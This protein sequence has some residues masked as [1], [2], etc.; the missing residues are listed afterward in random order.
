MMNRNIQSRKR[1]FAAFFIGTLI[2]ILVFAFTYSLSYVEFNRISNLQV[3]LAYKI[4]E[5]KLDYDL[6]E[7]DICS[8]SSYLEISESLGFQGRII[9]IL[10]RKL[11]KDNEGVLSR[12]KFYTLIELEHF[13]FVNNL[14]ENCGKE[15]ITLLFF[16]SNKG[17]QLDE[18]EDVGAMLGVVYDRNR[19]EKNMVI[20]SFDIDLDTDLILNLKEKY[21]IEKSPTIIINEDLKIVSH[22][23]INE[24]EMH[25][26]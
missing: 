13:E 8:D 16:Y 24:I 15:I 2:F 11:G 22:K 5:D 26:G 25:L 20:Y 21:G 3:N 14:K 17:A 10:E 18:S 9:D 7:G 23:N 12:K 4:F 1:Y 19:E 6:F